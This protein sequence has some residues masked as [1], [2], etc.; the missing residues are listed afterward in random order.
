[1][2]FFFDQDVLMELLE[3]CADGL[4]KAERYELIADIY[5][6]IIPIYE[7]R[8]D[9]EVLKWFVFSSLEDSGVT[10]IPKLSYMQE[11]RLATVRD[12]Q[13]VSDPSTWWWWSPP[14]EP[15]GIAHTGPTCTQ[16]PNLKQ[17]RLVVLALLKG[18]QEQFYN[19]QVPFFP[20]NALLLYLRGK[21][22][23][24]PVFLDWEV[25]QFLLVY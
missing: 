4:W 18:Y 17:Q 23:S 8:R 7:K 9:F 13:V 6:L 24:L 11:S 14:S 15:S 25:F 21:I 19:H 12:E 2:A 10:Y 20:H 5:K 22:V 3:Q 1:M 16:T